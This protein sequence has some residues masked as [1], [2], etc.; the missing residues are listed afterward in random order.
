M[1]FFYASRKDAKCAEGKKNTEYRIQNTEYR[2]Q[3]TEYR[4][5]TV[6]AGGRSA[7]GGKS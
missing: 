3:N 7:S 4:I 2:I 5:N 1:G 6:S